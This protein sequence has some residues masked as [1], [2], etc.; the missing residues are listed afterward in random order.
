MKRKIAIVGAGISGLSVAWQLD[1]EKNDIVVLS[2]AFSPDLTSDRAAAFW[3]PYHVRNDKRGIEWAQAS[4]RFFRSM[5]AVEAAGISMMPIVKAVP[6]NTEDEEQW[7]DFM[8]EGT[9]SKILRS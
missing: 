5:A 1:K 4:Y 6:E 2:K 8:P 7:M 3:F 9:V